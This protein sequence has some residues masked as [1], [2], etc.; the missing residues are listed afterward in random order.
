MADSLEV[1][2]TRI[3][4]LEDLDAVRSAIMGFEITRDG[5]PENSAKLLE[6]LTPNVRFYWSLEDI[7]I[8]GREKLCDYLKE[9][10]TPRVWCRHMVTNLDVEVRGKKATATW[11]VI[12]ESVS[13]PNLKRLR[14]GD[15]RARQTAP[16]TS[17][18]II[19]SDAKG[20]KVATLVKSRKGW[21]FSDYRID[22]TR[23]SVNHVRV[24]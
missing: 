10:M 24:Q 11:Y 20:S 19:W 9:G 14:K 2:Q 1:I 23:I 3:E 6:Y 16:A 15:Q 4:R 18:T 5:P 7:E 21:Q 12:S 17:D 13:K 8:R 22:M